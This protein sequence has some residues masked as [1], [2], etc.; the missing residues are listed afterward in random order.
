MSNI[1]DNEVT[2]CTVAIFEAIV[3]KGLS[4]V[5]VVIPEEDYLI[6]SGRIKELL[7]KHCSPEML[8]RVKFVKHLDWCTKGRGMVEN[9]IMYASH[10][11]RRMEEIQSHISKLNEEKERLSSLYLK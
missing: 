9:T 11:R 7:K 8:E 5:E 6:A 2:R 4:N 3:R 1:L 10:Y